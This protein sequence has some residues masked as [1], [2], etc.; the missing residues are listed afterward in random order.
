M[1]ET[2]LI[3]GTGPLGQSVMRALLK[4]GVSVRMAN[5]SGNRPAGVPAEVEII[6]G[7]AFNPDFTRQVARDA[8]VVYQ[9][10][11]PEYTQWTTHFVPLQNAILEGAAAAGAKLIVGDNLY[12][13]GEVNGPIHEDLPYAATT[14]KGLAR[15]EAARLVLAAHHSGKVRAA[16]G[17]ASDFFGPGVLDSACGDRMFLPA[18]QGK[19]AQGW[20]DLDA[21][22]TYSFIDDFGKGLVVLGERDEALGQAWHIPNAETV[23]TRRFIELIYENLDQPVKIKSLG[24]WMMAFGGLFIPAARE[25][26]EMIYEFEKPFVV[27]SSKFV[28]AFGDHATPLKLAIHETVGWYCQHAQVWPCARTAPAVS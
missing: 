20:G 21:P 10:A 14:R 12:M 16:I 13:Y 18:V 22:H 27:D 23:T 24:R 6:G 7:D 25:S 1:S 9:C 4:R 5:R 2:H 26:L 8:A 19:A 17:R 3:F 15:A 28:K 11:Q